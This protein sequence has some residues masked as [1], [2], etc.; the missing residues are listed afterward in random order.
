MHKKRCETYAI[1]TLL[2]LLD[3]SKTIQ[4]RNIVNTIVY[5]K[6]MFYFKQL[7]S[8][9]GVFFIISNIVLFLYLGK[10]KNIYDM[11]PA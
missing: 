6:T 9:I 1:I 4:L 3:S 2:L 11:Y 8:N 5:N 7:S 10:K